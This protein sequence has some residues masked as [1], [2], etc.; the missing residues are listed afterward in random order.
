M[1]TGASQVRK[2]VGTVMLRKASEYEHTTCIVD[3][4]VFRSFVSASPP[5]TTSFMW[6]HCRPEKRDISG[7]RETQTA[8]MLAN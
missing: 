2:P 6:P 1:A 3:E 4:L 5:T 7:S 8:R